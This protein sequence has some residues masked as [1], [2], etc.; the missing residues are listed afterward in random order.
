[1]VSISFVVRP[2]CRG[3]SQSNIDRFPFRQRIYKYIED[4]QHFFASQYFPGLTK[5][6]FCVDLYVDNL[7]LYSTA[8]FLQ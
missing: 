7:D 5:V 3:F 8:C 4:T 2:F 6:K 1:M